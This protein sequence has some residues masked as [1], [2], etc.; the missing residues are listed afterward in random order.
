MVIANDDCKVLN[1]G[2][3]EDFIKHGSVSEIENK[4]ELD[5]ESVTKKIIE[6]VGKE[7]ER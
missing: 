5:V 4:Y 2:Y 3:P 6:F 7:N 1:L